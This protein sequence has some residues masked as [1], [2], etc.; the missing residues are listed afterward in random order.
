M[1][2]LAKLNRSLDPK[3]KELVKEVYREEGNLR[4]G[5]RWGDCRQN[6]Y[7]ENFMGPMLQIAPQSVPNYVLILLLTILP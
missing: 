3:R 1:S 5:A 2:N 4:G 7:M 6:S